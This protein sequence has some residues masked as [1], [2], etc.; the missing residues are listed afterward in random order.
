MNLFEAENIEVSYGK[1]KIIDGISF[2]LSKNSVLGIL[3]VNG[4]GKTTLL[5]AI[6]GI[7]NYNGDC[8][9]CGKTIKDLSAKDISHICAYVPQ[10][11]GLSIDISALEVVLQ[12]F[13]PNLNLFEYP[14]K[15]MVE[16]AKGVLSDLGLSDKISENYLNLSEGQKQ[17]CI[18]ARAL[19]SRGNLLL[20]DEPESAIDFGGRYRMMKHIKNWISEGE[21]GA[22]IT[23]HDPQLALNSCDALLLI[24][25]GK[26]LGT[27]YPKEDSAEKI[28]K[29]L[30]EI[31]GNLSVKKALNKK[32]ESCFALIRED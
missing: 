28:E 11:S 6:C 21:R 31:Y 4:S 10:K 1:K 26:S 20:L 19:V 13:N 12:G 16:Q 25:K 5:K 32:G 9:V 7:N 17:I 3:G 27:I 18:L 22:I 30:C 2:S 15:K 29:M 8:K 14:N 23:L 24:S